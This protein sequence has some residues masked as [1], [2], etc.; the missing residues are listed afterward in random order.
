MPKVYFCKNMKENFEVCGET[1][2][3][4]FSTGRYSMCRKCR[5]TKQK[6]QSDAKKENVLE[7]KGNTIDPSKNIRW[8]IEDTII[9]QPIVEG[10]T[11][12]EKFKDMETRVSDSIEISCDYQ[13]KN[14][15][16]F[17]KLENYIKSLENK[18]ENLELELKIIKS[19]TLI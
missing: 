12:S 14:D 19:K 4:L 1:D 10:M 15:L 16:M 17:R 2:P 11:L 3:Q 7:E 9:R 13:Y 18:I 8:L 5:S 6:I